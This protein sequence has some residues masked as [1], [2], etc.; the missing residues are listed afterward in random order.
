MSFLLTFPEG[1]KKLLLLLAF[2]ESQNRDTF[3]NT[4]I[5]FCVSLKKTQAVGGM[6]QPVSKI[7]VPKRR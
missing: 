1:N 3:K 6:G 2:R 5:K 4:F 7:D